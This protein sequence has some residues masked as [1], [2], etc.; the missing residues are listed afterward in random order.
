[1]RQPTPETS[2]PAGK[3]R[4]TTG[5][6]A[7]TADLGCVAA[8]SWAGLYR[9]AAAELR[10]TPAHAAMVPLAL[11]VAALCCA[12]LA[13]DSAG[14]NEPAVAFRLIAAALL[15]LSAYINWRVALASGNPAEQVFFPSM[16]LL[17]YVLIDAVLR[18]Y[19]RDARR[20]RSGSAARDH[21]A[22][23]P[24]FHIATWIPGVG[25]PR[26]A[27]RA[28]S[29]ELGQ[30]LTGHAD[31]TQEHAV[32][33]HSLAGLTQSGAIRRAIADSGSQDAGTIVAWL[34][35]QGVTVARNRVCDV[36]RR[37]RESGRRQVP[38]GREVI[39]LPRRS[40]T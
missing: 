14:R 31:S 39:Q 18:K 17:S 28:V 10:W 34:E 24:R 12:L 40:G 2:A 26:R 36:L 38:G 7:L 29:H 30:R 22:P 33:A 35:G 20:D 1:M 15:G 6:L 13:L 21:A 5:Y 16:S 19:R 25:H 9:F 8:M 27:L 4:R 37:D 11:D 32:H 23:L 3:L